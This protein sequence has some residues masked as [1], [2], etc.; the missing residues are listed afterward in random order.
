MSGHTAASG[1]IAKPSAGRVT[2]W[3][4]AV[5]ALAGLGAA[6]WP[7]YLAR[8]AAAPWTLHLHALTALAWLVLLATQRSAVRAG[9]LGRHRLIGRYGL[10]LG[11]IV[12]LAALPP[13]LRTVQ[14][15]ADG[16]AS[17]GQRGEAAYALVLAAGALCA[18]TVA[19]AAGAMRR[20]Q[21]AQHGAWMMLTG[22]AL[23][24]AVV[25]RLLLFHVPGFERVEWAGHGELW[26]M[27]ACCA[28]LWIDARARGL[29]TAPARLSLLLYGAVH[30]VFTV[31]A[32]A[33]PGLVATT[34]AVDGAAV[35]R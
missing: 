27:E 8:L 11:P 10:W 23:C 5:L 33:L 31:A 2:P 24:G 20:R 6:F 7:N 34:P 29:P 25:Q 35:E 28:A 32:P 16:E 18:F 17:L 4:G 9:A 1:S 22:L 21:P 30:V 26:T 12:A 19:L 3:L 13:L 15:V 14:A